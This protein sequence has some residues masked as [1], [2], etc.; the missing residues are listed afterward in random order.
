MTRHHYLNHL[1]RFVYLSVVLVI[2][3]FCVPPV[4]ADEVLMSNGDRIAGE[5][6]RQ[7]TGVLKLKR[8][9]PAHWTSIGTM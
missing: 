8:L 4:L 6:V 9:M 2:S 7:E 5:I 3:V 1:N